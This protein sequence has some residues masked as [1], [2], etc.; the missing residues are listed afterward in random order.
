VEATVEDHAR[1]AHAAAHRS[2][3]NQQPD[4]ESGALRARAPAPRNLPSSR[5]EIDAALTMISHRQRRARLQSRRER[6]FINGAEMIVT[7]AITIIDVTICTR[8]PARRPT[9]SLKAALHAAPAAPH[10]ASDAGVTACHRCAPCGTTVG[11]SIAAQRT[12]RR[13]K[14]GIERT[15]AGSAEF[16]STF[17]EK[18]P[19]CCYTKPSSHLTVNE[20][21]ANSRCARTS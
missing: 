5:P 13:L 7:M 17:P 10:D 15:W 20:R 9:T 1:A 18:K 19:P 11:A 21:S 4:L 14:I 3:R 6:V 12:Q 2:M 8:L 16:A